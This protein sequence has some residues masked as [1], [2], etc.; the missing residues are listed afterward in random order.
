MD[1]W[2]PG[3]LLTCS[4]SWCGG[5]TSLAVEEDLQGGRGGEV[6]HQACLEEGHWGG[7]MEMLKSPGENSDGGESWSKKNI[8]RVEAQG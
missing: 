4:R 2:V 6:G 8:K 5:D 3:G 1:H 7:S